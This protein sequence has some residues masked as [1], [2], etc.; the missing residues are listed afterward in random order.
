MTGTHQ[1]ANS[2]ATKLVA[3]LWFAW[4]LLHI[5]PGLI[6]IDHALSADISAISFLFP[7]TKPE[8][9]MRDYPGEV[10]AISI[11]F[12]QHG[13]NLLWFGLVALVASGFIAF[14][15]SRV[16]LIVSGVVIGFADLGALFATFIIGRIDVVGAVI[17]AGTG[18]GIGLTVFVLKE[19]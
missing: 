2:K 13:F 7:E 11:T 16:V 8:A 12:G 17:F 5:L 6:T 3:L 15:P 4:S 1:V 9:V 19:R 14:R 18:L 10:R